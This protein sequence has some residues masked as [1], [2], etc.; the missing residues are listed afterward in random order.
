[1]IITGHLPEDKL[2]TGT[3][4]NFTRSRHDE[5]KGSKIITLVKRLEHGYFN[6]SRLL[7]PNTPIHL[8]LQRTDPSFSLRTNKDVTDKYKIDI[9]NCLLYLHKVKIDPV[10]ARSID[11]RLAHQPAI[12]PAMRNECKSFVIPQGSNNYR[13]YGLFTG[14]MPCRLL[15]TVVPSESLT[16]AG[17]YKNCPFLFSGKDFKISHVNFYVNDET[18]LSRPY[19][20]DFTNSDYVLS[21][22]GLLRTLRQMN[23]ANPIAPVSYYDYGNIMTV[24]GVD[25][26]ADETNLAPMGIGNVSIEVMFEEGLTVAAKGLVVAEYRTCMY[27][28]KNR[29]VTERDL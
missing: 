10:I 19:T 5:I 23:T 1:M 12:Y 14:R 8:E 4:A 9:V 2:T 29:T 6:C 3:G 7:L 22:L 17:S 28:D 16:N 20:P 15:F 26:T 13:Q 21:Y 27:I 25:L 11:A 18:V 24:F